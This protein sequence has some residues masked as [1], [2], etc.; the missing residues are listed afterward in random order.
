MA[1]LLVGALISEFRGSLGFFFG[2]TA[3][4]K[5][6]GDAIRTLAQQ[7]APSTGQIV[8]HAVDAAVKAAK[9]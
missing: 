3:G 7:A 5:R 1:L 4:N 8:G 2:T 6:N 9:R